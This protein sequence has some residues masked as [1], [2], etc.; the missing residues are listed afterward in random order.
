MQE[1]MLSSYTVRPLYTPGGTEKSKVVLCAFE[2]TA[3]LQ[4]GETGTYSLSVALEV[5]IASYDETAKKRKWCIC[6]GCW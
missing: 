4:P 1:R 2:K 6:S 5:I 3:L